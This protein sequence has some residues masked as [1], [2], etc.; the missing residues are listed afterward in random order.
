MTFLTLRDHGGGEKRIRIGRASKV[1]VL[2]FCFDGV[3]IREIE[4]L[5]GWYY[6]RGN[7]LIL[8]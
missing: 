6:S 4:V 5:Q 1:P 8:V 2:L 3:G 7:C